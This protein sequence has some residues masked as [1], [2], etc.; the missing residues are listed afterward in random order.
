MKKV[1]ILHYDVFTTTPGKG[2]P[3]GVVLNGDALA[4]EQMQYIAAQTGFT[5]TTFV[6]QLNQPVPR[7]RYF[8]P[9]S[10]MN[11]CGHGTIAAWTALQEHNSE[12]ELGHVTETKIGQ[13]AMETVRTTEGIQ[14]RMRQ[15]RARFL[16]FE[17]DLE[18]VLE[19]IGL[20]SHQ[21]DERFPVIYGSTGNWTLIIPVKRLKDFLNMRPDNKRFASVLKQIPEASIHPVCLETYM[22]DADMHG[23]HFSATQSGT[24]EDPVT[25]TASGVMGIYHAAYIN[26]QSQGRQVFQVEQGHEMGREGLVEVTV[27]RNQTNWEV[28]IAGISV[29]NTSQEITL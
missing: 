16:P 18:P 2:N 26:L 3:A 15:G 4:Q 1:E 24:E 22:S 27:N 29:R 6:C 12:R 10:E 8:S 9:K 21:L 7:L 19:S 20:E 5:E 28:M 17:G 11:L 23:R 25:G 14:I 13:L